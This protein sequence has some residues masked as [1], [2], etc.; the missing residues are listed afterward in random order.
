MLAKRLSRRGVVVSVG[1][2]EGILSQSQQASASVPASAVCA[3]IQAITLAAVGQAGV[4]PSKVAALTEGV[5]KNMLLSKL[6][7]MAVVVLVLGMAALGGG[8]LHQHRAAAQPGQAEKLQSAGGQGAGA[9]RKET[10]KNELAKLEGTWTLVSLERKEEKVPDEDLK[11][12]QL[13][14]KGNQWTMQSPNWV[15]S[16]TFRID[17]SKKPKTMDLTYNL[18]RRK[19]LL[20]GIYKLDSTTAGYTLT[21]C[22]V[23]R[24]ELPPPKEF[25][26]SKSAGVLFVW[27]RV[28]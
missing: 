10:V 18:P 26:T 16:G 2:L 28:R 5:M 15:D 17:L 25:K 22:R 7:R 24:Q 13:T 19:L 21:L 27:K 6:A 1:V 8:L 9:P 4:I 20:R 11:H 14:I 3:T 23:S 12:W